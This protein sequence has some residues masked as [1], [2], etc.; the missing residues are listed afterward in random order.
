MTTDLAAFS[1]DDLRARA[2]E[3]LLRHAPDPDDPETVVVGEREMLDP[4]HIPRAAAVL[5]GIIARP[6]PALLFTQR[7]ND[8]RVHAGQVSFPGGKRDPGDPSPLA[9]ALR[10]A[11]EEVGLD[12]ALVRPI[13]YLDPYVT[14]SGFG[15][16]GVVAEIDPSYR[17][18]LS[19]GEVADAFEVPFAHLMS[20]E[21][22][23]IES[24][25][26]RGGVRSVHHMPWGERNIWGVTAGM[27]KNLYD[28]LY[29][30]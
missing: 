1:L 12:P 2:A 13:G 30:P 10:E 21:N 28:R 4:G 16:I 23:L 29:G 3:R 9:T 25:E 6:E 20:E 17:L 27:V 15:I 8:L 11:E 24:R 19:P 26:W 14:Y 18:T 22:H 5:V 7:A